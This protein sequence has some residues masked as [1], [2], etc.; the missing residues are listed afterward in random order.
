ML[1]VCIL[2]VVR[3]MPSNYHKLAVFLYNRYGVE[4]GNEIL[5]RGNIGNLIRLYL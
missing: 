2:I 4:K 3:A 1:S 5:M